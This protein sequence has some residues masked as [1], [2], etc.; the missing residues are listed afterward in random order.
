MREIRDGEFM[1][2]VERF[3]EIVTITMPEYDILL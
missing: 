3:M 1:E 2:A